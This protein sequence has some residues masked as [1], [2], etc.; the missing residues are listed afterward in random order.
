MAGVASARRVATTLRKE[1]L[2][3]RDMRSLAGLRANSRANIGFPADSSEIHASFG[4]DKVAITGATSWRIPAS[5]SPVSTIS[6]VCSGGVTVV[7]LSPATVRCVAITTRR[8][9][10]MRRSA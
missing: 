7:K 2:A 4:R 8:S 3:A 10:A 1:R 5:S 9:S 6:S